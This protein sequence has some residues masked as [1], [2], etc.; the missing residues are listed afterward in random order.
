MFALSCRR[1]VLSASQQRTTVFTN[2]NTAVERLYFKV[3]NT[4]LGQTNLAMNF[5]D[6][7]YVTL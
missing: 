4:L 2:E 5:I 1:R 6:V 7:E 3:E